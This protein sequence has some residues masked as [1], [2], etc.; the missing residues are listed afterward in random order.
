MRK[1]ICSICLLGI[2]VSTS[3]W[4][5]SRGQLEPSQIPLENFSVEQ[6]QQA[7]EAGDPD[8]QYALGYMH[9][10]GKKVPQNQLLAI[11]WMKRASVQGQEQASQALILLGQNQ[12]HTQESI[13]ETTRSKKTKN[14][15]V[16]KRKEPKTTNTASTG[17]TIQLLNSSNKQ[18]VENYIK[19]HNLQGK[20]TYAQNKSKGKPSYTLTYGNYKTRS[21]AQ[22]A[23]AKLPTKLRAQKPW[24][25]SI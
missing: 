13:A 20:A 12:I 24:V 8:A 19:Q 7:A 3:I 15:A 23:A 5:L 21:E 25:K 4:A 6:L 11:N 2:F 17:Y 1:L 9:Y 18:K 10:Y 16:A 14:L 22:V